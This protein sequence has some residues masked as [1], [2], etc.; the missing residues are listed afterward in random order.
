MSLKKKSKEESSN[1]PYQWVDDV[2]LSLS[3]KNLT[4]NEL[5]E[6]IYAVT[7]EFDKMSDE[8]KNSAFIYLL[9]LL[10]KK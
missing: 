1:F 6:I 10:M 4:D 3:K 9:G 7:V 5:S 8:E 2:R